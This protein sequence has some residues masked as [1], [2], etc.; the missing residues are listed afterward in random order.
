M[1]HARRGPARAVV[2]GVVVAA[3]LVAAC[4]K[5]DPV[6]PPQ[7]VVSGERI[8]FPK[9]GRQT[10]LIRSANAD[11]YFAT[12]VLVPGRLAWNEEKTS[13]IF[14]PVAGR[15][16]ALLAAP[17]N[18]VKSGQA[19]ATISSPDIG[20][21]QAEVRKA[22]TD[23]ALAQKNLARVQELL[24]AGV[25]PEKDVQ[26]AQ[27]DLA[28]AQAERDRT[29]AREKLYGRAKSDGIDQLYRLAAPIGGIVVE[30]NINP[31]QEVRPDQAQPGNPPL[32]VVTDPKSLWAQLELPESLL[33][34]V[35]AGQEVSLVA[36]AFPEERFPARIQFVADAIDPASRTVK[37]RASVANPH[38]RLKAEM[39][40]NAEMALS[41][42]P[43]PKVPASAVLLVGD[44]QYVFV[45]RGDLTYERR[46]VQ[47]DEMRLG[48]MRIRSG[49]NA[50]EKVVVEGG[51]LLQQLIAGRKEK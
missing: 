11:A 19:L 50:G 51:L 39:F 14:S 5:P 38:R 23:L 18:P 15:V 16:V 34:V 31:G 20:Q 36:G 43:S 30:R 13:R 24:S 6:P 35:A 28:R 46:L 17:G 12:S 45:D 25:V 42:E 44:R 2:A 37:A 22:E 41:V 33:H 48:I 47:A 32:F 49:L 8:T 3:A 4:Q 10:A 40:V 7:A 27:A 1:T 9:D 26:A 29:R 21:A